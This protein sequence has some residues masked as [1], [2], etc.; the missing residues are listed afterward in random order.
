MIIFQLFPMIHYYNSK[1]IDNNF[2]KEYHFGWVVSSQ[3]VS[4][5]HFY[6]CHLQW[7]LSS[8]FIL[9]RDG[10][11]CELVLMK[12]GLII[13][14]QKLHNLIIIEFW[15]IIELSQFTFYEDYK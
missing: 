11:V 8:P 3:E 5:F 4:M 2:K 6:E 10:F 7:V 1:Q 14:T 9:M 15:I 13:L 12:H